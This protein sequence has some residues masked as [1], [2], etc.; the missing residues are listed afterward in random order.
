MPDNTLTGGSIAIGIDESADLGIVVAAVEVVE[1]GFG[2]VVV[3]TV[4]DGVDLGNGTGGGQDFAVRVI[5]I[6]ACQGA[7]GIQ[8]HHHV[9]LQVGHEIVHRAVVLH[10]VGGTV[11]G[12]EEVQNISGL[13]GT[14]IPDLPQQLAAGIGIDTGDVAHGLAG[15]HAACIVGEADAGGAAG[16]S[17]QASAIAPAQGPPGAVVIAD[18]AGY[19]ISISF[20][21]CFF[22]TNYRKNPG[23]R[24]FRG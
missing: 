8:N 16:C 6:A 22:N 2:I 20:V 24:G 10:G 19:R 23:I 3:A 9:A 5:H 18:G 11:I 4:T 15:S 1:A 13:I 21:Q 17:S 12:I 14:V 7:I